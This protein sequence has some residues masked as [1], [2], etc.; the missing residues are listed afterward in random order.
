MRLDRE[1]SLRRA[2]GAVCP[3]RR[4]VREDFHRFNI[5]MGGFVIP[6]QQHRG[7]GGGR[8]GRG[9]GVKHQPRLQRRQRAVTPSPGPEPDLALGGGGAK[10]EVIPAREH[11]P[12]GPP[13]H[14]RHC[15]RQRFQ[16]DDLPAE[17]AA[18]RHGHDAHLVLWNPQ[19]VGSLAAHIELPLGRCVDGHRLGARI[20][21]GDRR[22]R[23]HVRLVQTT[24]GVGAFNQDI[25]LAHTLGDVAA[26]EVI[27]VGDVAGQRLLHG[28]GR[29]RRVGGSLVVLLHVFDDQ[30]RAVSHS[31][32]R[33]QHRRQDLVLDRRR[34]AVG[35]VDRGR[36]C[37]CQDRRHRLPGVPRLIIGQQLTTHAFGEIRLGH[38]RRDPGDRQGDLAGNCDHAGV[39]MGTE[40]QARMQHAGQVQ[41]FRVAGGAGDFLQTLDALGRLAD[42]A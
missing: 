30:G 33:S 20:R 39:R 38:D 41:I 34:E 36:L 10:Q 23:F 35:A 25:G 3:V 14:H 27:P 11:E 15:R 32:G 28:A 12:D 21:G 40:H 6:S 22:M 24:G 37:L 19:R 18:D 17:P 1:G 2:G 4:L 13:L 7:D 26:R 8:P 29:H 31:L 16:Q 5:Q 42:N 9:A